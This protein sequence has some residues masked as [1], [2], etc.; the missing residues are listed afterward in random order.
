MSYFNINIININSINIMMT[1]GSKVY[2]YN[3]GIQRWNIQ[4]PMSFLWSWHLEG[5]Y[6]MSVGE[7]FVSA[8]QDY[9]T[10]Q[11]GDT[12]GTVATSQPWFNSQYRV[13]SVASASVLVSFEF[14]GFYPSISHKHANVPWVRL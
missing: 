5:I 14:F 7:E 10:W 11:Q 8:R 4:G 3:F 1:A 2:I 12:E 6:F 13:L 9:K